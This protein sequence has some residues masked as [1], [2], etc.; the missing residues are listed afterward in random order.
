[1]LSV[2]IPAYNE[3]ELIGNCL[4]A[5]VAQKTTEEFEVIVVDNN[6]RDKTAEIAEKYKSK[7]NLKIL[8]QKEKG[9]GAARQ[10]GFAAQRVTS[11][12][13]PTQIQLFHLFGYSDCQMLSKKVK[14]SPSLR[15]GH[16]PNQDFR[17]RNPVPSRLIGTGTRAMPWL[18]P[19]PAVWMTVTG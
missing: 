12:S 7:L 16:L 14:H 5:L 11:S 2:V 4:N 13:P 17:V 6:S 10:K 8:L 18:S 9:R 15:L 3:E 1:M 19:G